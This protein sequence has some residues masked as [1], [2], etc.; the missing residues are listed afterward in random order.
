MSQ[1]I[2]QVNGSVYGDQASF[3]ALQFCQ[4]VIAQGHQ[5]NQVFF[6]QD[7]VS[8]A[9]VLACPPS[10]EPNLNALW[11]EFAKAQ[12]IPLINCVSAA[13]RRGITSEQDAKE[14]GLAQHNCDEQFMMGG[15]G[16]LVT[17]IEKADRMVSF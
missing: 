7:G 8:N 4:A 10:D 15:L 14:N 12:S 11:R 6:Y 16:E 17:G 3:H 2:I 1:F 13:L 9:N 5:I